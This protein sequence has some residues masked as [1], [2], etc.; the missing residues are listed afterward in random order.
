MPGILRPYPLFYFFITFFIAL[1][2][3]SINFG[4]ILDLYNLY[5][6]WTVKQRLLCHTSLC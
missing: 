1:V 5:L 6:L 3:S 4:F 2:L